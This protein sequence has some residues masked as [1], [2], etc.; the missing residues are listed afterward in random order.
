MKK[1]LIIDLGSSRIKAGTLKD[2]NKPS[3]ILNILNPKT[4]NSPIRNGIIKNWDQIKKYF[5]QIIEYLKINPQE[6]NLS[7]S[8]C[9]T[10]PQKY[11]I[12]QF[13][14]NHFKFPKV[15]IGQQTI[16]SMYIISRTT[17]LICNLGYDMIQIIPIY[18]GYNINH[19]NKK[20]H[21]SGRLIEELTNTKIHNNQNLNVNNKNQNNKILEVLFSPKYFNLDCDSLPEEIDNTIKSADLTL[22][23]DLMQN[24]ILIGGISLVY[25]LETSLN[26]SLSIMN[27]RYNP[28]IIEENRHIYEWLGNH[29]FCKLDIFESFL[30]ENN[31]KKISPIT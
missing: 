4:L 2:D 30:V 22:R 13:I 26:Y 21:L 28:V 29:R 3:L 12:Y 27:K 25:G 31:L 7:L 17:G 10:S 16:Q 24:I 19:L 5:D 14:F 6:Y 8:I 9:D 11:E 23:L 18:Q 15:F 1:I 20:I